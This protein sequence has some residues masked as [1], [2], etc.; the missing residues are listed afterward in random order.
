MALKAAD[1]AALGDTP[2][3]I[4]S[5]AFPNVRLR[6]DGSSVTAVTES[7]GGTVNC[8]YGPASPWESYR[9]HPQPQGSGGLEWGAG[10]KGRRR[11]VGTAGAPQ[12]AAEGAETTRGSAQP[13][14]HVH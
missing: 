8:Q 7:G 11:M 5:A 1:L 10:A 6:M 9:V 14:M 12:P 2:I 13:P 3:T 4:Q